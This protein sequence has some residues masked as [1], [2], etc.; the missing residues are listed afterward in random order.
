[1]KLLRIA[2]FVV[3][4]FAILRNAPGQNF[5]N[6]NFEDATIVP[7]PSS[8]YYPNAVYTSDAIPGWTTIGEFL[9]T[10]DIYYNDQALGSPSV[11][12]Y[13][14]NSEY[15]PPLD[16]AYSIWLYGGY[17]PTTGVSISQTG[18]VP[19][20]AASILFIAQYSG[21]PGG[22]LLVSLGGQNI[23]FSAISTGSDYTMYGGNISSALDGQSEQ[24]IF[25]APAESGNNFWEIDDIQFSASPVPEPSILGLVALGSLFLCF[26]QI[27]YYPKFGLIDAGAKRD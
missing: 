16:G 21:P 9:G 22:I 4:S 27:G 8:P 13:G 2:Y 17:Y 19:N 24:L 15:D 25:N 1:M 7:D 10:N 5:I 11:A 26:R 14:T 12:L 23:S 20:D 3:V 6:L 18:L